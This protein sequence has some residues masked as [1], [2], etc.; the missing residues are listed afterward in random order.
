MF[1]P[2]GIEI[3]HHVTLI[4][5]GA[6]SPSIRDAANLIGSVL[7]LFPCSDYSRGSDRKPQGSMRDLRPIREQIAVTIVHLIVNI[8]A[9]AF[10]LFFFLSCHGDKLKRFI[11]RLRFSK[12]HDNIIKSF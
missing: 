5:L 2:I 11:H 9:I 3:R 8:G 4:N 7:N 10:I 12:F 1:Y 6:N